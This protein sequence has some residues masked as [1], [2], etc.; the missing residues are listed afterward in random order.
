MRTTRKIS[1]VVAFGAAL[2]LLTGGIAVADDVSNSIDGTIDGT[3]EVM[4][5][6]VGGAN[7]STMLYVQPQNDDGKNG[8]NL[9]G[10][11]TLTLNIASSNTSAAT[12]SPSSVTFDG[13]GAIRTLT[14]H[15]V[16]AGTT[17]VSATQASNDTGAT[18]NLAPVNFTVSVTGGVAN[19]APTVT[20][21]GVTAG[22]SYDKGSVPPA[23][24]SITDAED[25][26]SSFAA[27]PSAITGPNASD[28]IGS[29][30]ATCSYTDRGGLTATSSAVYAIVDPSAPTIGYTLS[31]ATPTGTNG[32]YREA[33]TLTWTVTETQSPN[34]LAKIGCVDQNITADQ[35]S[36]TYSCAATSA[37][38]PATTESVDLKKDATQP[39]SSCGT[40]PTGW[41]AANITLSCTASDVTSGLATVGDATYSLSTTVADGTETAAA[42]TGS[43]TVLDNA[44]N[45]KTV[46]LFTAM[47]DRKAPTISFSPASCSLPGLEGW[48]RGTQSATFAAVDGGSGLASGQAAS[49]TNST[50]TE[51]AAVSI[52]SGAVSDAVANSNAGID[53][54]PYQI[55]ST[56]PT[57]TPADVVSTTWRNTPLSQEFAFADFVSGLAPNQGLTSD[58]K[59]TL[60][61]AA[62]STKDLDGN[63]VPTV[64]SKTANDVA[65]NSVTRRVS[66]QI[67]TT[68]PTGVA[69]AGVLTSGGS[70]LRNF[71]PAAPTCTASDALSGLSSCAVTG[72]STA[73]GTHTL[74]ATATDVAGNQSTATLSYTVRTYSVSG[75][76]S[77]VDMGG[78]LNTVKGG[79]TVPLKFRVFDGTTEQT[80]TSAVN[81]FTSQRVSCTTTTEDAIEEL[82]T[83]GGTSLRYDTTAPQFI[84]NWKTPT[85]A[86]TCYRAQVTLIDSSSITAVFK[87]K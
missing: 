18:F 29:Q 36:Q 76:F 54:G 45:S 16:A 21:S 82:A 80:A 66:A 35:T 60:T 62:E 41:Q 34:S 32:W 23:T 28:G 10:S 72:Y 61:A 81:T 68:A 22:T 73:A 7:G 9:T 8:C 87:L 11:T 85:G 12:V 84:Q 43:K 31:P 24:C 44:N 70:Y 83:T 69:F 53:A 5:L 1:G 47:I 30:T 58:G 14:V 4:P 20:V 25:G 49:F 63:F 46:G 33:V 56:G 39:A 19:T 86:G 38:G 75:F 50:S 77:P 37:G 27:T 15:P 6:T 78:V 71:V 64:A 79:S 67:D 2:T 74:T 40:V 13:C 65:G 26:S 17:S 57:A 59:V 48:C 51:G 52:A 55:D 42:T 3:A